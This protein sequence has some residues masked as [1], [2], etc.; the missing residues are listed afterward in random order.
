MFFFG[1]IRSN[2]THFLSKGIEAALCHRKEL[3]LLK[4]CKA[5]FTGGRQLA[6]RRVDSRTI[7]RYYV[8]MLIGRAQDYC[9][10]SSL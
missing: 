5:R 9:I 4:T 2:G 3:K 7:S 6:A 8:K 10:D 1:E